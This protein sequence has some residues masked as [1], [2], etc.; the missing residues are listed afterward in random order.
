[1]WRSPGK[2]ALQIT[3][4]QDLGLVSD[5]AQLHI[6]CQKVVDSHPDEV[7]AHNVACNHE[8]NIS[9]TCP[10]IPLCA[11]L[12][13]HAIRSGNK[14]VLNKLMGLVQKETKGRADPVLV[15]A[16][17]QKKTSWRSHCSVRRNCISLTIRHVRKINYFGLM[18]KAGPYSYFWLWHFVNIEIY[19]RLYLYVWEVIKFSDCDCL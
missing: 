16:I 9:K 4:E 15:R 12:Q 2:T 11:S 19:S 7:R 14:K 17:L 8:W 6:I 13:V 10:K 1:M 18:E 3:Q 5:T